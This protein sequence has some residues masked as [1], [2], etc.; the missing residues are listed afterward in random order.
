[1]GSRVERDVDRIVSLMAAMI[2]HDGVP[3]TGHDED[4]LAD[5]A[6]ALVLAAYTCPYVQELRDEE[7]DD[8][9]TPPA[10]S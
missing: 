4:K 6:A 2:I 5:K 7:A 10:A 9:K 1:M 8:E 3:V